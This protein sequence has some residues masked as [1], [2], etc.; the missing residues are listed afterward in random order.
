M[1]NVELPAVLLFCTTPAP[2]VLLRLP[3][4]SLKPFKLKFPLGV[5]V[6]VDWFKVTF[7]ESAICC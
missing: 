7:D 2:P 6:P 1:V 4:V 3:M 5:P